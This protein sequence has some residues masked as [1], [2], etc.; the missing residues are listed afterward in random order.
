MEQLASHYHSCGWLCLSGH[1]CPASN[2]SKEGW[3]FVSKLFVHRELLLTKSTFLAITTCSRAATLHFAA[4]SS[5]FRVFSVSPCPPGQAVQCLTTVLDFTYN[6][7]FGEQLNIFFEARPV[8]FGFRFSIF[9]M[10]QLVMYP[11][12][13]WYSGRYKDVK[14]PLVAAFLMFAV[15]VVTRKVPHCACSARKAIPY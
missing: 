15:I 9:F 5:L 2:A 13:G 1:L 4:S 7:F 8:V 11:L 3:T 10:P 6:G 14:W 12:I